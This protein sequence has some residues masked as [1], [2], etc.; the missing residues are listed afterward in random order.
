MIFQ[1]LHLNTRFL[2]NGNIFL[3]IINL[4]LFKNETFKFIFFNQHNLRKSSQ[5]NLKLIF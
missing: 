5:G 4:Y 1:N 3:R 2:K